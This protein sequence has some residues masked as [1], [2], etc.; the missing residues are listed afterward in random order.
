[1][2]RAP[3]QQTDPSRVGGYRLVARL[4][5]GGMGVVYLAE[6]RDGQPVAVKVLRPELADNPEFRTRFG[7]EVTALTRIQGMCTV[8]VIEADTEAPK[9]FRSPSTPT[10]PRCPSTSTHMGRST[11]R[12]CTAWP[13]GS[14]RR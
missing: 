9:P 7:R 1:M 13:P 8:R 4:G 5:A 14:P 3:L 10:A 2:A 6:T 11:P 12:C